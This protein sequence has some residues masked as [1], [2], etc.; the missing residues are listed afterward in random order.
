ME[1]LVNTFVSDFVQR[2]RWKILR[3]CELMAVPPVHIA[4]AVTGHLGVNMVD[5][6]LVEQRPLYRGQID[7]EKARVS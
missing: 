6:G 2:D 4:L 1:P 3:T 5:R 7:C